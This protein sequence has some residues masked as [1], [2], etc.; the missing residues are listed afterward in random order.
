MPSRGMCLLLERPCVRCSQAMLM[1]EGATR[2]EIV[3]M[4]DV[5]AE[6]RVYANIKCAAQLEPSPMTQIE[7]GGDGSLQV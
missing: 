7:K 3:K 2:K 5:Q 4:V 6:S 1:P